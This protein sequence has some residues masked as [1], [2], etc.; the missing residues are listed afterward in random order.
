MEL[1][2]NKGRD[3]WRE[4]LVN[5]PRV[6]D[7]IRAAKALEEKSSDEDV[8]RLGAA[9]LSEKFWGVGD[10]IASA[11]G[12]IGGEKAR[13]K[14]LA[15]LTLEHPKTRRAVVEHLGKFVGDDK[16][17]E[18]LRAVV[19]KGDA[20]YRVEAEAIES[21]SKLQAA[22]AATLLPTLLDRPSHGEQIRSAA[23]TGIGR[24]GNAAGLESLLDW[25][26]RGKPRECR[27]AA[28]TGLGLLAEGADL[29]DE[30][31]ERI[32]TSLKDALEGERPRFQRAVIS[33]LRDLGEDARPAIPALRVVE[34][35]GAD[36]RLRKAAADAIEKISAANP[37][38]LQLQELRDELT[39]LREENK[40]M[41]DQIERLEAKREHASTN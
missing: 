20:S 31:T 40:A 30:T 28:I 33:A 32:V 35:S 22:D 21:Y 9:L 39:K 5:G 8:E 37:P 3:L 17:A 34:A 14:L 13:D 10:A 7:R 41:R 4:Q 26:K 24:T 23:L 15:A 16:V 18:A 38:P 1:K 29:P 27:Q 19:T 6:V 12:T 36:E 2:E 11:L 25:M